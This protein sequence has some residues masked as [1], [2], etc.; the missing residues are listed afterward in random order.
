M[1]SRKDFD[2]DE[3]YSEYLRT[4]FAA[5]AMQGML[6]K[7]DGSINGGYYD[8]FGKKCIEIADAILIQLEQTK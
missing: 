6:A 4:Y 7:G 1:K 8:N 3:E 2:S 5:M